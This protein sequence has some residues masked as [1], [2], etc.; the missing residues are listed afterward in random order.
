MN[1]NAKRLETTTGRLCRRSVRLGVRTLF[2]LPAILWPALAACG[3]E[4][5]VDPR[6]G[7]IPPRDGIPCEELRLQDPRT[8]GNYT[9][10]FCRHG[11]KWEVPSGSGPLRFLIELTCV[12]TSGAFLTVNGPNQDTLWQ[13]EVRSGDVRTFCV[14]RESAPGGLYT[15][16]LSGSLPLGLTHFTGSIW[17][18]VFNG[19]GEVLPAAGPGSRR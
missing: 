3:S 9:C 18:N 19:G 8:G 6:Q 14:P 13:E 16:T 12:D 15:V 5:A 17:I 7:G 10:M 2:W 11:W 1:P 4:P